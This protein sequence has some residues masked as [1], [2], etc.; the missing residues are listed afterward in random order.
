MP[1]S[2]FNK[3]AYEDVWQKA[4]SR[5]ISNFDW[6]STP[7]GPMNAWAD[8]VKQAVRTMLLSATPMAVFIGRDGI[9]L[10]NDALREMFGPHYDG[11]LAKP[12]TEVVPEEAVK[13]Y[14]D[15][16]DAV[17][18]GKSQRFQNQPLRLVRKGHEL[19][20]FDL[21]FTPITD[22]S[23]RVY[24]TLLIASETTQRVQALNELRRSRE[25]LELA[26]TAGGIVGT[27]EV[28]FSTGLVVADERFARLH[29]VDPESANK[30]VD[31][32]AF[33]AGI[34]PDD[35][36]SVLAEFT[37]AKDEVGYY[38]F[39]HRVIGEGEPRWIIS[40]GKMFPDAEGKLAYFSGVAVDVTEQVKTLEALA[41][42]EAQFKTLAE[43]LPQMIF[44][45]LPD[46]TV[47]YQNNRLYE[48]TGRSKGSIDSAVWQ[49][50]IHPDDRAKVISSWAKARGTGERYDIEYRFR[51]HTG[52]YR[53]VRSMA[54]PVR[55]RLG[56][57]ARWC[58]ARTDINEAKLLE[59]QRE[60]VSNE[61]NHRIKNIFSIINA[62]IS[63]TLREDHTAKSFADRLRGRLAAFS[64][65]HDFVRSGTGSATAHTT[66]RSLHRL[67]YRLLAPYDSSNEKPRIVIEGD[68]ALVD[69]NGATPIALIFHELATNAAKYGAL[70]KP[71]GVIHLRSVVDGDNIN[72]IWTEKGE[73]NETRSIEA[74]GFGSKLLVS[75][76][77]RQLHGKLTRDFGADGLVVRISLPVSSLA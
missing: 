27:W 3:A 14:R 54:L 75:V 13:F 57:I 38:R 22:E 56:N 77:E 71:G 44:S 29:G 43:T 72:L 58:G 68:D 24:G 64:E 16:I 60:L 76:V 23:G 70:I 52:E 32:S 9:L 45:A 42:S 11:S 39:Q 69:E 4:M 50:L 66:E 20:W 48:F 35:R 46:D 12:V 67:I 21:S 28:D 37:R 40:S 31:R 62:L 61:L 8:S 17:Y 26:L 47:I 41:E 18:A 15:A 1:T 36:P 55:D 73:P 65:A 33:V 10:H 74:E 49:D 25:R 30:G 7:L 59:I 2:L 51:H 34:Y 53:W 6:A 63:L 19:A 5:S